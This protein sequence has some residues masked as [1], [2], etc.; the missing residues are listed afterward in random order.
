MAALSFVGLAI[1]ALVMPEAQA[2]VTVVV[3]G[4]LTG[5]KL[6]E[7]VTMKEMEMVTKA[8]TASLRCLTAIPLR[9]AGDVAGVDDEGADAG[10]GSGGAETCVAV[11]PGR[12]D[13][14]GVSP[15]RRP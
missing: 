9:L 11:V 3:S 14:G 12:E 2:A 6:R 5:A 15:R 7:T 13:V 10:S 8:S 4:W 1:R